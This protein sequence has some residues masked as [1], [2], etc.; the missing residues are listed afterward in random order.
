MAAIGRFRTVRR[1]RRAALALLLFGLS[2]P[3]HAV[4]PASGTTETAC[5]GGTSLALA[6]KA[7]GRMA[8]I[9]AEAAR[10]PNGT[11]RFWRI[12]RDGIAPSYLF[13]TMHL[14]DPRVLALPAPVTAALEQAKTVAIETLDVLDATKSSFLVLAHPELM[15]IEPG[16]TLD[17]YLSPAEKRELT[18]LMAASGTPYAAIRTLQPWFYSVG[19]MLPACE[20]ARAA[21]GARPLDV[22]IALDAQGAGKALVGLE[23]AE[24]QLRVLASMPM[25]LQTASLIAT[26]RIRDRIPDLFETMTEFYLDGRVAAI[27]PLSDRFLPMDGMPAEVQSDYLDFEKRIV[28]D[29]NRGMA[30]GLAPHLARGGVFVAVGALHLPDTDGLVELLRTQGYRLTRAD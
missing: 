7:D 14:S 3:A 23:T 2:G 27:A 24:S 29:R 9:D 16:R 28:A 6:L 8:A 22:K 20:A 5:K 4:T 26:L 25:R 11:G 12:E 1:L 13:G 17:D 18:D 15:N 30:A 19:L 10:I 21:A